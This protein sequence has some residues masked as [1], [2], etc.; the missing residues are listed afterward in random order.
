MR[1][2]EVVVL[3]MLWG[4]AL[5]CRGGRRSLSRR[6]RVLSVAWACFAVAVT[7][8][9]PAVR[10]VVD[11]LIGVES[12][13]NLLVH[14]L[15]L[16]G[17]ATMVEFVR[18]ATGRA[19]TRGRISRLNLA[20]LAVAS[21]VVTIAFTVMPRPPGDIDLL[22]YG[23][24]S[25]AGFVYW[26]TLTGYGALGLAAAAR[27]SWMH[28][29]DATRGPART[30]LWLLRAATLLGTAYLC[31][32]FTYV[33]AHYAHWT[34]PTSARIT[35]TTQMLLALTLVLFALAV[36]WPA[37]TDYRAKR[38]TARR[39]DRIAPLWR[40]MQTAAPGMVLP[41]PAELRR[42]NPRLRLYRYVI[43]IRDGVL[44]VERHL[45]AGHPPAAEAALRAAGVEGAGLAPAVEAVLLRYAV[46]AQLAGHA[47]EYGGRPHVRET[48]DLAAE[49]HWLERVAAALEL[50]AVVAAA[51]RLAAAPGA[52]LSGAPDDGGQSM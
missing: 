27:I 4:L 40:L 45:G 13:T 37:L 26:A 5:Y 16:V 47:P 21:T 50:P 11:A 12:V 28:G 46:T 20:T 1:P 32:R 39:A 8:G 19:R 51:E 23:R 31:H 44:A 52:R 6:N 36:I 24:S 14:L 9:T 2:Y 30:F 17:T 10:R 15:G 25:A 33:T 49:A 18:E 48:L 34:L 43:E 29:K 35:G 22:T 41:L 7:L 42:G 38:T 3:P